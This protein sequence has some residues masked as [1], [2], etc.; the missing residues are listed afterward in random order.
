VN[1]PEFDTPFNQPLLEATFVA[2]GEDPHLHTVT[3]TFQDEDEE[4]TDVALSIKYGRNDEPI[5]IGQRNVDGGKCHFRRDF[6]KP[7]CYRRGVEQC[8]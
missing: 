6:M 4:W 8:L 5:V 1:K 7:W 2:E 3:F